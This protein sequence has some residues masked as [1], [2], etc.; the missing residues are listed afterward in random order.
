MHGRCGSGVAVALDARADLVRRPDC[1][2]RVEEA[3]GDAALRPVEVARL[4]AR[5]ERGDVVAEARTLDHRAVE[6]QAPVGD[7]VAAHGLEGGGAVVGD[8]GRNRG[9]D[10]ES[11]EAL[12]GALASGA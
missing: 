12:A 7:E 5:V 2:E 11:L 10:V 8:R 6:R 3:V 4:H 9:H 1:G